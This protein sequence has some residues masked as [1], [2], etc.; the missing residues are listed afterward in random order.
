MKNIEYEKLGVEEDKFNFGHAEFE[1]SSRNPTRK[2]EKVIRYASVESKRVI[3][4]GDIN[5]LI[6]NI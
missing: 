3:W 1:I 5:F 6:L 4:P 2:M